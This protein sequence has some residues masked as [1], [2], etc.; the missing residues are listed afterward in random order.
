MPAYFQ[1]KREIAG[2]QVNIAEIYP[3]AGGWSV[4]SDTGRRRYIVRLNDEDRR[5]VPEDEP[6]WSRWP[7]CTCMDF[8]VRHARCKHIYAV[9]R[10]LAAYEI[11]MGEATQEYE[12][13]TRAAQ[14]WGS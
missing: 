14:E 8:R 11:T 1:T 9:F 5:S 2:E 13:I 6:P 3:L 4:P 7:E 10:K 12:S